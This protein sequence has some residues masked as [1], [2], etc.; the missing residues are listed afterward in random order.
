MC[1]WC[2]CVRICHSADQQSHGWGPCEDKAARKQAIHV[3][4]IP[5]PAPV[6]SP[7][8]CHPGTGRTSSSLSCHIRLKL[9]ITT[10]HLYCNK[11]FC[12]YRGEIL[13][14]PGFQP[15]PPFSFILARDLAFLMCQS[16]PQ[17]VAG[18]IWGSKLSTM[19]FLVA[20]SSVLSLPGLETRNMSAA[21]P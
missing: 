18:H 12:L 5:P 4:S 1:V 10:A 15:Q 6:C 17:W 14:N 11:W 2:V 3:Q 9:S 7:T 16:R 19:R 13:S 8:L 20:E 21:A